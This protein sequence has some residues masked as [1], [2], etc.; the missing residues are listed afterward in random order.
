MG[1]PS[2][3]CAILSLEEEHVCNQHSCRALHTL[4]QGCLNPGLG[5]T[6]APQPP[7][8]CAFALG[9]AESEDETPSEFGHLRARLPG[10]GNPGLEDEIPL[11]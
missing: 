9:F 4:A 2:F 7:Q 3:D 11:G 1:V 10:F 8:G 5:Q 6:R